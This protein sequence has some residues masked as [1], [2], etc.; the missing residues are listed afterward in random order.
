M[1]IPDKLNLLLAVGGLVSSCLLPFP[2]MLDAT[3]GLL[4]GGLLAW[5]LRHF[6]Y[7]VRRVEGLGLGDVK[8][9]AA[10]GSWTGA[11]SL[12]PTLFLASCAALLY[13]AVQMARNIPNIDTQRLPF[14]PFLCF[15]LTTVSILQI[16]TGRSVYGMFDTM[17]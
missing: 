7:R 1:I 14:G 2:G 15:G 12:A 6:Y 8:F 4:V 10:A 3:L 17:Y 9:I 11:T 13:F 16:T 5:T